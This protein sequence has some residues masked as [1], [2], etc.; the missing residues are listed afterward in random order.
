MRAECYLLFQR[1]YGGAL[2]A[3]ISG[4]G[5][6]WLDMIMLDADLKLERRGR[7]T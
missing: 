3:T 7:R 5:I 2:L 4:K 1:E 6:S